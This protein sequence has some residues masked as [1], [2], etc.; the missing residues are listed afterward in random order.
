MLQRK[1]DKSIAT[2]KLSSL[3]ADNVRIVGD[4]VFSGGLRI[5]GHVEGNVTV[6]E[7]SRGL[8]VLSEKGHIRGRVCTY[9]A[10]VNGTIAGELVAHHFLELQAQAKVSGTITYQQLKMECGATIEGQIE[11]TATDSQDAKVIDLPHSHPHTQTA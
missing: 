3:I 9:D 1:K 10:V 6:E 2:T 5:D 4:V 7:G 11:R 8:L